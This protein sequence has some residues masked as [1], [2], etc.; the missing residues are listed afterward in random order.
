MK[1]VIAM[2]SILLSVLFPFNCLAEEPLQYKP[3]DDSI[4]DSCLQLS[5][6][7][8]SDLARTWNNEE[9]VMELFDQELADSYGE[10]DIMHPYRVYIFYPTDLFDPTFT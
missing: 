2:L 3:G 6:E 5:Y 4:L 1:T 7:Q 10:E 9:Q 8:V